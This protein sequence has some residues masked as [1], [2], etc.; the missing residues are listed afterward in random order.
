MFQS[1]KY[2]TISHHFINN[3]HS[4]LFTISSLIL[5][6]LLSISLF[7]TENK[8]QPKNIEK[9]L[10]QKIKKDKK[11]KNVSEIDDELRKYQNLIDSVKNNK[12]IS[13][14]SKDK[15]NK[16][17]KNA[18][19]SLKRQKK[20]VKETKNFSNLLK[21][22]SSNSL[23]HDEIIIDRPIAI[24]EKAR[25]MALTEIESEITSLQ[26]QLASEQTSLEQA[27][28]HFGESQT[29]PSLLRKNISQYEEELSHLEN[30]LKNPQPESEEPPSVIKAKQLSIQTKCNALKAE[31]VAAEKE[32]KF[33][34]QQM[35]TANTRMA[36]LSMK[37][38]KLDN[39]IKTWEK[40]KNL[41]QTDAGYAGLRQAENTLKI[42]KRANWPKNG[43]FLKNIVLRNIKLAKTIIDLNRN[44][45]RAQNNLSILESR[46]KQNEENFELTKRRIKMMGLTKKTGKMLQARRATIETSTANPEIARK[47]QDDILDLSL[48][49]DD[50]IVETQNFLPLKN[51]TYKTLDGLEKKIDKTKYDFI[52]TQTFVI[53]EN[54][55]NLLTETTKAYSEF[56]QTL[57]NQ[58]FTQ[59]KLDFITDEY[60][61]YINQNMLWSLST[62]VI[63]LSN[64]VNSR[65]AIEWLIDLDNWKNLTQDITRS[66][67]LESQNWIFLLI[68]LILS[69][70]VTFLPKVNFAIKKLGTK[71]TTTLRTV[72]CIILTII[73]SASIP[74]TI[75][76][77]SSQILQFRTLHSFTKACFKSLSMVSSAII[78]VAILMALCKKDGLGIKLFKWSEQTCK[79]TIKTVKT[80]SFVL[81]PILFFIVFI[82]NGPQSMGYR[83][84]LGRFLFLTAML[85]TLFLCIQSVKVHS[86]IKGKKKENKKQKRSLVIRSFIIILMPILM[87]ILASLG[88]YFTSYQ[89]LSSLWYI[90]CFITVLVIIKSSLHRIMHTVQLRISANRKA[91]IKNEE[92]DL[93]INDNLLDPSGLELKL[94]AENQ[95]IEEEELEEKTSQLINFII[96][97]TG[98]IG[99]GLILTNLIPA[100]K[101]LD[102]VILWQ[103]QTTKDNKTITEIITLFELIKSLIVFIS[104]FVIV[105][106]F[107]AIFAILNFRRN[108]MHPGSQHALELIC[109]YIIFGIG[110]FWGLKLIGIGWAQFQ[111]VA[112]A[113]TLGLSFG[114]QDIFANFISGIIILFEKP[115]RLGDSVTVGGCSG[116]V[117]KIRIRSTTV[118]DFD[119]HELII[120]NKAFLTDRITNW[121]LSD[122]IIRVVI[123]VGIGYSSDAAQAESI[124]LKIAKR[125]PLSLAEPAPQVIFT[126]F[127]SD[128]LDFSLRV[129]T[130]LGNN[131]KLQHLLRHEINNKFKEANIEIP[132]AQRDIHITPDSN[133]LKVQMVDND[134]ES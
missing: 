43:D 27:K 73:V 125:N 33:L 81:I 15:I 56:L 71:P 34:V 122:Q 46:L 100:I 29:K 115:I 113:M 131:L 24:E 70:I 60:R 118:T 45:T 47:R 52:T 96:Y 4:K 92:A 55:R 14:E 88:Y 116:T 76:L 18:I 104:T 91:L 65:K 127:G 61:S 25:S 10:E 126:G 12:K 30:K 95:Q 42:T 129:F 64:I 66:F 32:S 68:L 23:I 117:T 130:E 3:R 40:V 108:K 19:E 49:N 44:K 20:A 35:S 26:S 2:P 105:K 133:T 1:N 107:S 124:L 13:L 57:N 99:I 128:S 16:C 21:E 90:I 50:I 31:L 39:V 98:I 86:K 6:F 58:Q 120:P 102:G 11:I 69:F 82:Q 84:T 51:N 48:K 97:T 110:F 87:F 132:F 63:S 83:N 85:I 7:A 67:E 93:K 41:R 17:Y 112:A 5:F 89:L 111:Y 54:Y 53:L 59:K 101:M 36:S 114:L 103:L 9:Q 62:D 109:R 123:D 80:F 121:S 79:L 38:S 78:Y 77:A 75:H 8:I 74:I 72:L 28:K 106:N 22:A 37:V 119:R 94:S 134:K